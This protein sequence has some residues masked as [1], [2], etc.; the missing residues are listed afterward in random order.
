MDWKKR[1]RWLAEMRWKQRG[2]RDII[3]PPQPKPKAAKP[4]P[5]VVKPKFQQRVEVAIEMI[6]EDYYGQRDKSDRTKPFGNATNYGAWLMAKGFQKLGSGAHSAVYAKPNSDKVIK[7]TWSLDNWI[8]YVKWAASAG[9]A[10]T[11]APRVYSWKR[12]GRK[13]YGDFAVAVVERMDV[14]GYNTDFKKH[15]GALL[16]QLQ[17]PAR[18]GS[19]LAQCFMEEIQ[20]GSVNFFKMLSALEFDGDMGGNNVMYRKDGTL[21]ITDPCAGRIQ[22]TLRRFRS[23]DLSPS[24]YG[25]N[26]EMSL[27]RNSRSSLDLCR[28][29]A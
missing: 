27:W 23:G 14:G 28:R 21:C 29:S 13:D 6:R 15:D 12:H 8:D 5:K 10:G 26:Y 25:L 7:V 9:Y 4:E 20:P 2:H 17:Y 11:L 18:S 3:I 22:T 16:M 24:V 19:L 1:Q